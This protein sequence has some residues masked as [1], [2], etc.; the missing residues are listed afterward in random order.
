MGAKSRRKGVSGERQWV[1]WLRERGFDATRFGQCAQRD[2]RT[3]L[4]HAEISWECKRVA[5]AR[6]VYGYLEHADRLRDS[7]LPAV[8]LR[9]DHNEW[10]VIM[11]AETFAALMAPSSPPS[12][13]SPPSTATSTSR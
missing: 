7:G 2:V 8:A 5:R 4:P 13:T 10:L 1:N 9:E 6:N 11:T 3:V 12:S